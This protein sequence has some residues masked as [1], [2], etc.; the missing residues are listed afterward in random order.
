MAQNGYHEPRK[1][2]IHMVANRARILI[3]GIDFARFSGDS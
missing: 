3:N 1:P 2:L